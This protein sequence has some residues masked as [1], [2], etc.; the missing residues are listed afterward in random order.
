[1]RWWPGQAAASYLTPL[2]ALVLVAGPAGCGNADGPPAA[3][4]AH[5]TDLRVAGADRPPL[6]PDGLGDIRI[7]MTLE[8]VTRVAGPDANPHLVGGP[9]PEVCDEFRP[10]RAPTGTIVMIEHGVLTRISLGAGS[11]VLTERGIGVGAPA[12][13][14]R[15][16]Y[17]E[18]AV[19]SP[20]KYISA[21]AE[22][23]KVVSGERGGS[24]PRGIV[25]EVGSDGRVSRIHAGGPSI[26]YV[27]GCL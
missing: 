18:L 1:V 13:A 25:Y 9:E 26:D 8:E 10:E 22:Y 24:E 14:V 19:A 3:A 27:E 11:E 15:E 23:L 7:G 16:A 12:E 5:S 4:V 2:V 21:P 6:T 17:G 20:H